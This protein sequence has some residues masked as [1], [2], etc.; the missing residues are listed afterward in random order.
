[1]FISGDL[2]REP[3][4]WPEV[5]RATANKYIAGSEAVSDLRREEITKESS[6]LLKRVQRLEIQGIKAVISAFHVFY[7]KERWQAKRLFIL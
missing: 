6:E 5:D 2:R 3:K 7:K 4:K 1:M